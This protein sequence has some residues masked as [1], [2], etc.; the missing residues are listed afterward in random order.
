MNKCS[1]QAV[2]CSAGRSIFSAGLLTTLPSCSR[3]SR[4]TLPRSWAILNPFSMG[5]TFL[6]DNTIVLTTFKRGLWNYY[7]FSSSMIFSLKLLP[8]LTISSFPR[9]CSDKLWNVPFRRIASG[10]NI[11]GA[12]QQHLSHTDTY[13]EP[14]AFQNTNLNINRNGQLMKLGGIRQG[15]QGRKCTFQ[16]C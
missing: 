16:Y 2:L 6:S 8:D 9:F 10:L 14:R 3:Q 12:A 5:R 1:V 7:I 13:L 4:V 11:T 15:S